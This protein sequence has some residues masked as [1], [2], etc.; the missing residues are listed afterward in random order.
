MEDYTS[1]EAGRLVTPE[2]SRSGQRHCVLDAGISM[3]SETVAQTSFLSYDS[4]R[5]WWLPH[6]SLTR[7]NE[8]Y[9]GAAVP[10]Q[11]YEA[12]LLRTS[13]GETSCTQR[14][15]RDQPRFNKKRSNPQGIWFWVLIL[16]IRICARR[17]HPSRWDRQ[18]HENHSV[19]P[20]TGSNLCCTWR[21]VP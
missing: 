11:I 14:K 20:A 1:L 6:G 8:T 9:R 17:A 5:G 13:C 18:S 4:C 16:R 10:I 21:L 15:V 3:E 12:E 7:L 2:A 19:E